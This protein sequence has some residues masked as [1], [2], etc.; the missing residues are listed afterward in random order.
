[1]PRSVVVGGGLVLA[2]VALWLAMRGVDRAGLAAAFRDVSWGFVAAAA[3]A[4]MVTLVFQSW[5]WRIG[6]AEGGLGDVPLRHTVAAT[7]I[8][9]AANQVL[10][11][12]LGEVARV[13]II[14]RHLPGGPGQIPKIV[15]TLVA[16]RVVAGLATFGI[17]V[18]AALLLPMPFSV[19]GGRWAPFGAVVG[20][21]AILFGVRRV[22]LGR[23]VPA[24][25]CSLVGSLTEGAGLLRPSPVVAKALALQVGALLA[26]TLTVGLLLHAFGVAAPAEASLLVLA[27]MAIAGA[28]SAAPGGLGV[29][30]FAIVAPLG[31]LYGVGA[32]LAF[33]FSLGLQGTVAAV[34]LAGGLPALLH[35]R[36]ARTHGSAVLPT[37]A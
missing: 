16:Q 26:Q 33:A 1:M 5:S 17:V 12:K 3:A 30:Q 15:G 8:A 4:N 31:A 35:Q 34:A 11:A 22:P 21:V 29:T 23:M 24:R 32:D 6:I 10:P 36:F 2:A 25:L 37:A 20:V 14:R 19:P 13:M 28:V 7:W 27:M 18:T 9:K